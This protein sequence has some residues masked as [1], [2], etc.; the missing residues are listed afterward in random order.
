MTTSASLF[1]IQ[2]VSRKRNIK[3]Q[4][5]GWALQLEILAHASITWL[6][7]KIKSVNHL[8]EMVWKKQ[9]RDGMM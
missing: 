6:T 8:Q 1:D 7:M 3:H 5:K 9:H 4:E 2:A